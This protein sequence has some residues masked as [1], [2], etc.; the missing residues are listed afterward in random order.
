MLTYFDSYEVHGV[1]DVGTNAA[2]VVPDAEADYWS[3]YGK[4]NGLFT[5]VGDFD[6]RDGAEL[7]ADMLNNKN[8]GLPPQ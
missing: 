5:C 3:I 4:M 1:Q 2:K 8:L 6:T 7:V